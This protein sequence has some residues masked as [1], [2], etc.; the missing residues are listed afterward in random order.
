MEALR[1]IGADGINLVLSDDKMPR[2]DGVTM[3]SR[4]GIR[5]HVISVVLLGT[6][7]PTADRP[8]GPRPSDQRG[9]SLRAGV[10]TLSRG[11]RQSGSRDGCLGTGGGGSRASCRARL[12]MSRQGAHGVPAWMLLRWSLGQGH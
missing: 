2:L 7:V 5:E 10:Q 6:V 3:A 8:K 9:N 11:K 1:E 12:L 4:L